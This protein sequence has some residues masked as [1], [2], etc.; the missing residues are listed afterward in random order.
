MYVCNTSIHV[1][2]IQSRSAHD[3]VKW[4]RTY[5]IMSVPCMNTEQ[6]S[7][8]TLYPLHRNMHQRIACKTTKPAYFKES[9]TRGISCIPSNRHVARLAFKPTHAEHNALAV[10]RLNHSATTSK[11]VWTRGRQ[12]EAAIYGVLVSVSTSS[13]SGASFGAI[14]TCVLHLRASLYGH[15]VKFVPWVCGAMDSTSD[16]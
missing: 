14:F 11:S 10:H 4:F 7:H 2:C 15:L 13:V 3:I 6:P 16:V 8:S 9:Y 5:T 12:Q 1:D